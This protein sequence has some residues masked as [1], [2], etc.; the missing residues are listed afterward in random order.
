ME[1]VVEFFQRFGISWGTLIPTTV[2][3][4]IVMIVLYY[5]AYKP[6]LAILEERKRRIAES[7]ENAEKIKQE[8]ARTQELRAQALAEANAQAQRLIQ[9]ARQTAEQVRERTVAEARA[10]AEAEL[11]RAQQQIRVERERMLAEARNEMVGLVIQTSAKV[12][13]KILT[14]EDHR[15]LAEETAR[16]VAA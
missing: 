2:N 14:P 9:E 4:V 15:R 7:M 3:F 8:L 12:A 13:G 6:I 10:Q 16:E 5:F 1:P 11:R